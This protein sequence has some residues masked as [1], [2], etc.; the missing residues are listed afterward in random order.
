MGTAGRCCSAARSEEPRGAVHH[1]V[2][3]DK[4]DSLACR[5]QSH[6]MSYKPAGY[7]DLAP[8]LLVPDAEAVLGFCE[9]VLAGTRLRVIRDDDKG[10]TMQNAVL[11]IPS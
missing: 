6:T 11:A 2:A 1:R 10:I 4:L 8:Y 9:A 5:Y 7:T 3:D